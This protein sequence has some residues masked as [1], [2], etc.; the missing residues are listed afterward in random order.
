M[1]I[2]KLKNIALKG[3]NLEENSDVNNSFLI[4]SAPSLILSTSSSSASQTTSETDSPM[5]VPP[6]SPLK[7]DLQIFQ[8]SNLII[9]IICTISV[10]NFDAP[11]TK[12]EIILPD[13]ISL[14]NGRLSWAFNLV[15][16][17]SIQRMVTAEAIKDGVWT[18]IAKA[19]YTMAS[20]DWF[21]DVDY[22]YVSV[23][24]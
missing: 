22:A 3:N 5:V 9:E 6:I 24:N 17:E 7:V 23:S 16:N 1:L 12:G 19:N 8:K 15:K 13:G 11:D 2:Q 4:L 18:I 14:I 20:G 10:T 21:G